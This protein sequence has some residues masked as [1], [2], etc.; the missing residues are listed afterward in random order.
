MPAICGL[1]QQRWA[2]AHAFRIGDGLEPGFEAGVAGG[3]GAEVG[4]D[5]AAGEGLGR[6][7]GDFQHL[8]RGQGRAAA[9][10]AEAGLVVEV[11]LVLQAGVE[12]AGFRRQVFVELIAVA[13]GGVGF[14]VVVGLAVGGGRAAGVVDLAVQMGVGV[15]VL[16]GA[17]VDLAFHYLVLGLQGPDAVL[18]AAAQAGG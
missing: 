13:E 15:A 1:G 11:A 2:K 14:G 5:R 10:A 12:V 4:D 3:A 9:G 17:D 7:A 6:A 16:V 18:L 8:A